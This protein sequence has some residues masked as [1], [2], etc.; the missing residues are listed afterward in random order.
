M[1]GCFTAEFTLRVD[2]KSPFTALSALQLVHCY[3]RNEFFREAD[4]VPL[5]ITTILLFP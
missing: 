1:S 2:A 4:I 3:F 5:A